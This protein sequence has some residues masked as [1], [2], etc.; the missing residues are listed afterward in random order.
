MTPSLLEHELARTNFIAETAVKGC[1]YI[2]TFLEESEH[3]MQ[4]ENS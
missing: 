3:K 4:D 1:I 2:Y